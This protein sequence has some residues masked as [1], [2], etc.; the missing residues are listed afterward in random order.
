MSMHGC[1]EL[2]NV[3]FLGPLRFDY[4]LILEELGPLV[5]A[6]ILTFMT[7]PQRKQFKQAVK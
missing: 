2:R 3:T 7:I 5:H 1:R 6:L 4:Q